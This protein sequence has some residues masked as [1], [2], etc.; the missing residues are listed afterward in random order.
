MISLKI[1][2]TYKSRIKK[3]NFLILLMGS[4]IG[5]AQIISL[6]DAHE[7]MLSSNGNIKASSFE[8]NQSQE[9]YKA[10]KGLYLPK[11]TA[12]GTYLRIDN[13]IS[14]D[15]NTPRD[16]F[17]G[18]LSISNPAEV[19][20]DWNFTLQEKNLG[21]ATLGLSMPLYS[22]GLINSANKAAKIKYNLAKNNH[23]IVDN[24]YTINL[25]QLY[26]KLKLAKS[27]ESLRQT[28]YKTVEL[29][30]N[31]ANKFFENGIIPEVETLNA[32]VALSNANTDLMSSQKDLELATTALENLIGSDNV[33]SLSTNFSQPN[34]I[35]SLGEFQTDILKNN[36]QLKAIQQN[37]SLAEV[38]V[39]AEK[40]DYYPKIGLFG[41]Y[42]PWTD[43][44]TIT[45][46]TKWFVGVG[47]EWVLFD[48]L[49]RE[50]KIKAAQYKINQ[51]EAIDSQAK[52]NLQTYSEKLYNTMKKASEQYQSLVLNETYAQKLKFMR[53]RAFEEGTGTS[54]E[55]VDATLKL[56]QIQFHKLQALYDYN[57]AYGEL[58][59]VSGQTELFLNQN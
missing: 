14:V 46:N 48:G 3:L 22:G 31:Q 52:L 10:A 40:S 41:N 59:V 39:K 6:K 7:L 27:V 24:D 16:M 26:Y 19:L 4:I 12:S 20:G 23:Q 56:S 17:G 43:N 42:V 47:V 32:Q 37:K 53:T 57:I 45:E 18:L 8:I 15:L 28:I 5:Q 9:E 2:K 21:F 30:Y 36:H 44:L 50:H 49:Q 25:I 51:V 35:K 1:K 29:H 55:V 54:L 58:M 38:G 11:I 33:D 34:L 13:D